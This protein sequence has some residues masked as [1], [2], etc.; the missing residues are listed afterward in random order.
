MNY[1]EEI[2][3]RIKE[4]REKKGLSLEQLS[5]ATGGKLSKSRI[6]NYEQ[7]IRMPGPAEA[8][9][10]AVVL[11]VDAAHLMCLQQVFSSQAIELMRNWS[12]LPE[13][14]RM[15]YFRRIEVMALAYREPVPDEKLSPDVRRGAPRHKVKARLK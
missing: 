4:A 3:R 11:G 2:G 5:K 1:K 15:Q 10:L 7:G 9:T 6:G 14:E 13:N 12:A 8:N